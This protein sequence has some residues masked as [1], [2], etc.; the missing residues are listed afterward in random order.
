MT[1]SVSMA[2]AA[3]RRA[4]FINVL[5]LNLGVEPTEAGVAQLLAELDP[6]SPDF[7]AAFESALPLAQP[8]H[9]GALL[10]RLPGYTPVAALRQ[11][12]AVAAGN[13]LTAAL[14]ARSVMSTANS[15]HWP[16]LVSE[17]D[18]LLGLARAALGMKGQLLTP[19]QQTGPLARS[20]LACALLDAMDRPGQVPCLRF[21][22]TGR[23]GLRLRYTLAARRAQ[24]ATAAE[25]LDAAATLPATSL[26]LGERE[27]PRAFVAGQPLTAKPA[28]LVAL[29]SAFLPQKS[30]SWLMQSRKLRK[31]VLD[32]VPR[33]FVKW[34]RKQLRNRFGT[35]RLVLQAKVA[36]QAGDF[37]KVGQLLLAMPTG[38]VAD[39]VLIEQFATLARPHGQVVLPRGRTHRQ[40]SPMAPAAL[41]AWSERT[42]QPLPRLPWTCNAREVAEGLVADRWTWASLSAIER[43]RLH[44]TWT[45]AE[46]RLLV[47][48]RVFAAV[49]LPTP[50][51]A[52]TPA[53][54]VQVWNE[55]QFQDVLAL[56]AANLPSHQ[57]ILRAAWCRCG[58]AMWFLRALQ[59]QASP[60][61]F[62]DTVRSHYAA[63][64][65]HRSG[66]KTVHGRW[67][68]WL[69]PTIGTPDWQ[70][71]PLSPV[72][73]ESFL[74]L[75]TAWWKRGGVPLDGAAFVREVEARIAAENAT[76]SDAAP[77][78]A[79]TSSINQRAR[80]LVAWLAAHPPS[81]E[82]LLA[83]MPVEVLQ[84][85]LMQSRVPPALVESVLPRL[86]QR[87]ALP[88]TNALRRAWLRAPANVEMLA[89]ALALPGPRYARRLQWRASWNH[90]DGPEPLRD[91]CRVMVAIAE[92][93]V[94]AALARE[95]GE[96]RFR[97]ACR[98]AL[99]AAQARHPR[100]AA[101]LELCSKLP[102]ESFAPLW[103]CIARCRPSA[104]AGHRLDHCYRRWTVPK[105]NGGQRPIHAPDFLLKQ[106]QRALLEA[107]ITPLGAHDA[108]CGFV[109]GIGI[110]DNA[111]RHVG[112]AVVANVDISNC[113][114]SVRWQR[115]L[116]VLRRD[117][118]AQLSTTAISILVDLVTAEGGLPVGAPTSPA[119]L[120]RVLLR[121]DEWLTALAAN[122]GV[123][124]SRYADDL[125]FSGG[126]ETVGMLGHA[127]RILAQLHLRID[128][129]K[130]QIYR[131]GGRQLVTGLVVNEQVAVPREVRRRLRAAMHAAA[132]GRETHWNGESQSTASLQGRLAYLAMVHGEPSGPPRRQ[133]KR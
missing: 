17:M 34:S 47:A 79:E 3:I 92:P 13:P 81:T 46:A 95:W 101:Y 91:Q 39:R 132:Q 125:T 110:V 10:E 107:F 104:G 26:Y 117:L 120:N 7:A 16:E 52:P 33:S 55:L 36:L 85:V 121:T 118:A 27:L 31:L 58:D 80:H 82:R 74:S 77:G 88:E 11:W 114:P 2:E 129:K 68:R 5:Q 71:A 53:S 130:T 35:E 128:A 25:L 78:T 24:G 54:P 14:L 86:Q 28:A 113:F 87:A 127:R 123:R 106:T 63:L 98:A 62:R 21:W 59:H 105:R 90:L 64:N 111:S 99:P 42:R 67:F 60:R 83:R 66:S 40:W 89:K 124:Y 102:I 23:P 126:R 48:G 119:L 15:A 19:T 70:A 29:K 44:E 65:P 20:P 76:D 4:E 131:R 75:A 109:A 72:D 112:Q 100:V 6:Y 30:L 108:A 122:R 103:V 50:N 43:L 8:L 9:L 18:R 45:L 94:L 49:P 61:I 93:R 97:T 32:D 12:W 73:P 38:P 96:E 1:H 115:V 22:T 37:R 41:A 56:A 51:E 69:A 133:L 57:A 84:A 116:G